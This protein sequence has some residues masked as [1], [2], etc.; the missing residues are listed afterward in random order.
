MSLLGLVRQIC[1]V[2]GPS[3]QAEDYRQARQAVAMAGAHGPTPLAIW[4]DMARSRG[5]PVLGELLAT[6]ACQQFD[7]QLWGQVESDHRHQRLAKALG[8]PLVLAMV[9]STAFEQI[10]FAR[11]GHHVRADVYHP[12]SHRGQ[13]PPFR[14]YARAVAEAARLFPSDSALKPLLEELPRALAQHP[15]VRALVASCERRQRNRQLAVE[16]AGVDERY[17]QLTDGW[18]T[19]DA[20][21]GQMIGVEE[22]MVVEAMSAASPS[23]RRFHLHYRSVLRMR[24]D[25]VA[26]LGQWL[27]TAGPWALAVPDGLVECFAWRADEDL[28]LTV[29]RISFEAATPGSVAEVGTGG[30]I[31]EI[32]GLW[33]V[34]TCTLNC[35]RTSWLVLQSIGLRGL[36]YLDA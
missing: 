1:S 16:I 20:T 32:D 23:A 8:P 31:P 3:E 29:R 15:T 22:C 24:D 11:S 36:S 34:D 28:R 10:A 18:R 26:V 27:G 9:L 35:E 7:T 19:P 13:L 2:V 4:W 33:M 17:R 5:T 14:D 30:T 12:L 21:L 6:G 25:L